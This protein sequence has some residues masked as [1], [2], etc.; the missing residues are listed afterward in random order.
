MASPQFQLAP[1]LANLPLSVLR[2]KYEELTPEE[3]RALGLVRPATDTEAA[4]FERAQESGA[5]ADFA[6]PVFPNPDNR[7]VSADTD[8]GIPVTRLPNGVEFQRQNFHGQMPRDVS[9]PATA[10]I[11]PGQIRTVAATSTETPQSDWFAQN[12]PADRDTKDE[13]DW[14]AQNAPPAEEEKP[15]PRTWADSAGDFASSLWQK[16]SPVGAIKG[17]AQMVNHPIDTFKQDTSARQQVYDQAEKEFKKGNYTAGATRLLYSLIPLVGPQLNAAANDFVAGNYARGAG[18]ST[19]LGLALAGPEALRVNAP[20]IAE[21]A[22][23]ATQATGR[24][25]KGAIRAGAE[26]LNPDV[27]GVIS[28]RAGEVVRVLQRANRAL[29]KSAPEAA[30]ATPSYPGAPLPAKPPQEVLNAAALRTGGKAAPNPSAALGTIKVNTEVPEIAGSAEAASRDTSLFQQASDE[31]GPKASLSDIAQRAQELKTGKNFAR[32]RAGVEDKIGDLLNEGLGGKPLQSNIPL[33][34]Q[35]QASLTRQSLPKDFTPVKSS[36]IAGYKYDPA[37]RELET[38]TNNGQRY[39]HGDVSP[40]E[41]QA[42]ANAESKGKAWQKIR[43]NPL[44]AKVV[45]GKRVPVTKTVPKDLDEWE[46]LQE[47]ESQVENTPKP[48]PKEEDLTDLLQQSLARA[49]GKKNM[50]GPRSR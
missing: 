39:I 43:D 23:G 26:S 28:P 38:V 29:Q 14:F 1:S 12:A 4:A 19:G 27:V 18:A 49:K 31:L 11:L 50:A 30:E 47:I 41:A 35:I 46:A 20:A 10:Q 37:A 13:Q 16:I 8:S 9:N 33:K 25:A 24:A 45:N 48:K 2:K 44:V 32:E 40:E 6:G 22:K 42:F 3:R 34:D 17:A 5:P 15:E 7:V 36:V 21:T